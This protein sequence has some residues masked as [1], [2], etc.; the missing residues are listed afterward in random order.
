MLLPIGHEN[1]SAR[2]WPVITL[3]LIAINV[4]ALVLTIWFGGET[5][6]PEAGT[7][8]EHILRLV[9]FHPELNQP[10]EAQQLVAA[11]DPKRWEYAKA[12][13]YNLPVLDAWDANL[14]MGKGNE[15][16]QEEMDALCAQYATLSKP[17]ESQKFEFIPA[18]P[19]A[20]SYVTANFLHGGWLHLIGNMWFLLLAGIVLE[21]KWGRTIYAIFYLAAGAM[22]LQVFAWT[23]PQG[24]TPVVGASGAVAG[25]MG[26]FLVRFPTM[27]IKMAWLRLTR[28]RTFEM[29]AFWLLPVWLLM[30][31]FYGSL[32]GSKD[33]VAHWAHVGGFVFGVAVALLLRVTGLEHKVDQSIDAKVNRVVATN[34][35]AIIEASDLMEHGR[36]DEALPVLQNF[37]AANPNNMDACRLIQQIHWR[38]GNLPAYQEET[39]KLCGMHLRTRE[40]DIAWQEYQ[41]FIN[42][43]GGKVPAATW[44]DLC[45]AAES[46]QHFDRA[47]SEYQE[48]IAAYPAE[49][50]SV[51][52]QIAA[53]KLCV[54]RLNRPEDGL[55]FYQAAAAS[56]VPHLDLDMNIEAGIREAKAAMMPVGAGARVN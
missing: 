11:V 36:L 51:M 33:G 53:G 52:A 32:A 39:I 48:L 49:R 54:K 23:E 9:L 50:Q 29:Q 42:S 30:E 20:I 14:R 47:L 7:V 4:I 21:D 13:S 43:G 17:T 34:D 15:G 38:K 16:L 26:A 41:D 56:T 44:I 19:S 46:Q 31:V 2:R 35:A 40:L 1:M 55:K 22:A 12:N 3:A 18:H 5:E 27:K 6:A 8:K 28:F 37:A 24:L 45:R 25:L 10:P